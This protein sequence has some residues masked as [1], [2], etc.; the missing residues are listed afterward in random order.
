MRFVFQEF[1]STAVFSNCFSVFFSVQLFFDCLPLQFLHVSLQ[2]VFNLGCRIRQCIAVVYH[3]SLRIVFRI[4]RQSC[5]SIVFQ[6]ICFSIWFS[7]CVSVQLSFNC[8]NCCVCACC[9]TVYFQFVFQDQT[10]HCSCFHVSL[11]MV[12]RIKHSSCVSSVC[13]YSCFSICSSVQLWFNW[14][15]LQLFSCFLTV[16]F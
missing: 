15:S 3:C 5:V 4:E 8:F 10:V 12:F 14:F 16:V 7:I 2:I 1:F 6:F 13:Q 9:I 11:H